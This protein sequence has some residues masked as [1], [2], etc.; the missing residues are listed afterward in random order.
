M[1]KLSPFLA[2]TSPYPLNI[3]VESA[4]GSWI[5]GSNGKKYLDF[6]SGIGVSNLGHGHPAIVKN[7][8]EQAEKH[9]HVM[10]YGEM[11]QAI[12]TRFAKKLCENTPVELD[13]VYFVNSGT[14]A[15]EAAIKLARRVT[16][17]K[18]IISCHKSYHGCS[19]G[20]LA[21]SGN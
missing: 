15:N 14:E 3:S 13:A 17:R 19:T 18:E 16:G 6:I 20:S 9:L 11:E 8:Q 1:Q 7:I 5:Y 21:I 12:Q 2:P 10:V 4:K